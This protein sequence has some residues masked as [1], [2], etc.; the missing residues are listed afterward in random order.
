MKIVVLVYM[1]K[2]LFYAITTTIQGIILSEIIYQ[3]R[4][5]QTTNLKLNL[6]GC[7][8]QEQ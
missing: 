1:A 7:I 8:Q 2:V 3:S 6:L 4:L 5:T